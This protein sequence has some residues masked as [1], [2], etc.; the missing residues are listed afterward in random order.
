MISRRSVAVLCAAMTTAACG[1]AAASH[2][3]GRTTAAS[4][5]A[6]RSSG[7]GTTRSTTTA[8]RPR[9]RPT[10]PRLL[11]AAKGTRATPFVPAVSIDGR[12][13]AWVARTGSG[14]LLLSFDQRLATLRLHSGTIDAGATGWRYGPSIAGAERSKV[15]AAFN[16][17]FKLA[18]GAGGF[19]SY[20]RVA[21]PLSAGLGSIV[22][23]ANGITD[24]GTWHSQVPASG[25]RVDSVRQ[26]LGLLIDHGHPAAN[27]A[28]DSC[29]GATLGGVS[30]PARSALGVTADGRLIWAGAEH[31]TVAQ[32]AAALLGARVIRAVELDINPEW[33][34]SYLYDRVG[35]SHRLAAV[36]QV[37]GQPG[38]PGQFLV[39]YGRDF[40]TVT[41]R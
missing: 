41:A 17:A 14:F 16:G 29:W 3:V 8:A 19:S 34:A 26:N 20:G 37:P 10:G 4:S 18:V 12:T 6:S 7:S 22:T 9:P 25:Q 2:T 32:L 13:A 15:I 11:P 35:R 5:H 21:A 38:V 24:I 40:F 30:D 1:S 27:V 36:P 31:A 28:C 23:Y 39:P 33:V